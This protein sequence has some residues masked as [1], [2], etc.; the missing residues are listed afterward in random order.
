MKLSP[1]DM[2]MSSTKNRHE[3]KQVAEANRNL[4]NVSPEISDDFQQFAEIPYVTSRVAETIECCLKRLSSIDTVRVL[5]VSTGTGRLL[6]HLVRHVPPENICA[7]DIAERNIGVVRKRFPRTKF[8]VEDF[9]G[10]FRLSRQVDLITCYSVMHHFY[11]WESLS[12]LEKANRLLNPGGVIY[13]DHEPLNSILTKAY[14][15]LAK[16]KNRDKEDLFLAEYHQFHDHLD[17]FQV[18]KFLKVKNYQGSLFHECFSYWRNYQ[19]D[20]T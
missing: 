9:L 17:P 20:R 12:F 13:L 2:K 16:I 8:H 14:E 18:K 1:L 11:D 5:D 6:A 4:Y 15:F 3:H 19:K 10:D 7:I